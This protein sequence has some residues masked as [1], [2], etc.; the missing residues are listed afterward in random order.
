M[1]WMPRVERRMSGLA[2]RVTSYSSL[3]QLREDALV[4]NRLDPPAQHMVEAR[5]DLRGPR[6]VDRI[7]IKNLDGVEQAQRDIL[8][9]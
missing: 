7:P 6:F 9:D 8:A 5:I 1:A 2:S 4:R 3:G